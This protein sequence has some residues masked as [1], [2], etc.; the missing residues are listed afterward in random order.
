MAAWLDEMFQ[1]PW[2][3]QLA[4]ATPMAP[5]IVGEELY[6]YARTAELLVARGLQAQAHGDPVAF[7][8]HLAT[9]LAL[10]RQGRH[11]A[12][13]DHSRITWATEMFLLQGIERWLERQDGRPE[14]LRQVLTL[15]V[16]HDKAQASDRDDALRADY[17]QA[18]Y[19]L[20]QPS[21]WEHL[22]HWKES[23]DPTPLE[24]MEPFAWQPKW[25][26]AR[27]ERLVRQQAYLWDQ[28]LPLAEPLHRARFWM[29]I[30]E[31]SPLHNHR[32]DQHPHYA[33]QELMLA[34]R[35]HQAEKGQPAKTLQ[36][37]TPTILQDLPVDPT[38]EKPFGYRV[39]R[40]EKVL[41]GRVALTEQGQFVKVMFEHFS[42]E[43]LN[44]VEDKKTWVR[45]GQ[46]ILMAKH[47]TFLVPLPPGK[48]PMR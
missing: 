39:S 18:L 28:S 32:P 9:G 19:L 6:A 38:T 11:G 41:V 5:G 47:Y 31:D 36:E 4:K 42:P 14:L 7:V 33:A 27:L 25:E 13:S 3:G 12:P 22:L 40:G 44:L 23:S 1:Q 35:I 21:K 24:W 10:V 34:L 16:D 46:G 15:L 2:A 26:Q 43:K 17:L 37:L 8:K 48:E 29:L 45:A 30:T 20:N